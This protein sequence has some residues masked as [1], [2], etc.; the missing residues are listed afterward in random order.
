MSELIYRGESLSV[1][2]RCR[3]R[4][5]EAVDM[6]GKRADVVMTDRRGETVFWF[7]THDAERK[8]VDVDGNYLS[9]RLD[10]SD[11]AGLQGVYMVEIRVEDGGMVQIAQV[12]GVR[13][14]DSVTGGLPPEGV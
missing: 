6:T 7:S 14:L 1:V 12:P 4:K 11:M 9:C 2:L 8:G 13:V 5:G 10:P 3:D